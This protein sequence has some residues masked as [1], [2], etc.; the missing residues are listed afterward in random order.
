MKNKK[1]VII[2]AV[3]TVLSVLCSLMFCGFRIGFVFVD[4]VVFDSLCY[5]LWALFILN[6]VFMCAHLR[7]VISR[8]KTCGKV[9]FIINC[10]VTA[11]S[12]ICSVAFLIIGKNELRNYVYM[13][14]ELLPVLAVS[15][16]LIFFIAVF[17]LCG[18]LFKRCTAAV[19]A[20]ACVIA[21]LIYLFPV[22]GFGFESAPAVFDTG[23]SYHVIFA[24]NRKSIGY[25]SYSF[26]GKD[27]MVWDTMTGRKEASTV[28]SIEIPHEH[29]DN[30]AY[31]VGAV[32]ATEEIPYGGHLGKEIAYDVGK[33]TPCPGDNFDMAVVTDNHET[34]VDWNA[35]GKDAEV[36]VFLGDIANGLYSHDSYIDNLIVPAGKASMGQIPVIYVRGNHDHRGSVISDMLSSLDFDRYYYRVN[37]GKYVFTVLDT[38]E[39]KEDGNYEYAGYND[40]TSYFAEQTAW[41]QSLEKEAGYNVLIAHNPG[42]FLPI[43]GE[44][45]PIA[46]ILRNLGIEF[47]ISGHQHSTEFVPAEDSKIGIPYYI[48]G[49]YEGKKDLVYTTMHFENGH[50][51]IISE[52]MAGEQRATAEIQ[53]QETK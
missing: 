41:A 35:V 14:F 51:D 40:Y 46:G 2:A 21:A 19:C 50:I 31:S 49:Y 48:S 6:S 27:Y 47:S 29:L 30:N 22:G 4:H 24:T 7:S 37:I 1:Q 25:I 23:D 3:F 11:L 33:F 43:D 8:K 38:G 45:Q 42:L 16:G 5:C 52:N 9:L 15:Y 13:S 12:V 36:C 20:L 28:H 44:N 26:G 53:L 17:P 34:R 39:D 32:R 18:K 10:A